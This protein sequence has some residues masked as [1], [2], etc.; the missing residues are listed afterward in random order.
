[1]DVSSGRRA[2][3]ARIGWTSRVAHGREAWRARYNQPVILTDARRDE[4]ACW[5]IRN[6]IRSRCSSARSPSAGTASCTSPRSSC[7]WLLGRYRARSSIAPGWTPRDVEDML[8]YGVFGVI[9][10]GRLGYVLF[11]NPDYYLAHPLEIFAVW[12]GGMSFHGGFLG[13][14][15]A[16]WLWARKHGARSSSVTDFVAPLVPLGYAVGRI[17]N[18]I[19]AELVGRPTDVPWAMVFPQRRQRAAASVAALPRG[20][21]GLL[22]FVIL[23]WYTREAA[24]AR[25]AVGA[26]PDRLRPRAELR[27][28]LPDAGLRRA[29]VR[30]RHHVGTALQHSDGD[31]RDLAVGTPIGSR[32]DA[33]DR[34]ETSWRLAPR[35]VR[36]TRAP[37]FAVEDLD[38]ARRR[39]ASA[40]APPD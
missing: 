3:L 21:E 38:A 2:S 33:I 20:L 35:R 27:R 1:M 9:L 17:G 19:N 14:L 4:S 13:V 34:I 31:R 18:F 32:S 15:L 8:F 12:K 36:A 40:A 37:I 30:R 22:L 11:Y 28:V 6:S 26:V 24:A 23:W 5:F 25:R 10:G 29:L 7:S 16:L 39:T